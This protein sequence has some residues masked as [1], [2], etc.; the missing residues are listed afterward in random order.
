MVAKVISELNSCSRLNIFQKLP[1]GYAYVNLR[2]AKQPLV[3][4][5][6]V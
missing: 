1:P 5:S 2:L 6:L 3:I 4:G